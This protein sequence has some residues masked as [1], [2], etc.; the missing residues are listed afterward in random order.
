MASKCYSSWKVPQFQHVCGYIPCC[1][2]ISLF[3]SEVSVY[4]SVSLSFSL[5]F[6]PTP[7]SPQL[8]QFLLPPRLCLAPHPLPP[9]QIFCFAFA[10][11]RTLLF[12]KHPLI[13]AL[14]APGLSTWPLCHRGPRGTQGTNVANFWPGEGGW[15]SLIVKA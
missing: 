14:G 1:L 13:I 10:L 11:P 9:S 5:P 12:S 6:S 2:C 7:L 8:L 3:F 15:E 4:F